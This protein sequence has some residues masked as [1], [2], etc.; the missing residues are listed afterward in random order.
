MAVIRIW[1]NETEAEQGNDHLVFV[2]N[3]IERYTQNIWSSNI[4]LAV[5]F[6]YKSLLER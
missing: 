5:E 3:N 4:F 1:A 6:F 2:Q